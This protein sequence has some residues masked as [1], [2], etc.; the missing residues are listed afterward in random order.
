[1]YA[2]R[3]SAYYNMRRRAPVTGDGA[4]IIGDGAPIIRDGALIIGDGASMHPTPHDPATVHGPQAEASDM[5]LHRVCAQGSACVCDENAS[6]LRG[7]VAD[8]DGV[9]DVADGDGVLRR[10]A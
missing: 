9:G 4:P 1:M 10:G 6:P 2:W 5:A 7:D 3:R 8:G